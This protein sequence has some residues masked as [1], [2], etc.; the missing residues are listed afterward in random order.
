ML[1]SHDPRAGGDERGFEVARALS[2]VGRVLIGGLV[3]PTLSA[4]D[5]QLGHLAHELLL[6][7][8]HLARVD[9]ELA[10]Q[11]GC[12]PVAPGCRQ[13][14]FGLEGRSEDPSSSAHRHAPKKGAFDPQRSSLSARPKI[15]VHLTSGPGDAPRAISIASRRTRRLACFR[16]DGQLD[17]HTVKPRKGSVSV[18]ASWAAVGKTSHNRSKAVFHFCKR[19]RPFG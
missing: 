2:A 10:R 16:T 11:L 3:G 19:K 12:R 15:G 13:G 8:R 18:S 14:P 17:P 1:G 6:S 5:E 7:S 9:A 4:I